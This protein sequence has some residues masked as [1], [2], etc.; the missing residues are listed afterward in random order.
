MGSL[1]CR[2]VLG[3]TLALGAWGSSAAAGGEPVPIA[4]DLAGPTAIVAQQTG[5]GGMD[6]YV[7]EGAAGRVTRIADGGKGSRTVVAEGL[8]QGGLALALVGDKTLVVGEYG[9]G[10]LLGLRLDQRAP[11]APL[12]EFDRRGGPAPTGQLS[13]AVTDRYLFVLRGD[14]L[15]RA[16]RTGDELT[17]L[18]P[19]P[20]RFACDAI[21]T[22]ST[23]YVLAIQSRQGRATLAFRDPHAADSREAS[24]P[25]SGIDG[26]VALAEGPTPRPAERLLYALVR[27]DS[28]AR[29]GVVRLDAAAGEAVGANLVMPIAAPRALAFAHD[30]AMLVA[31]GDAES[32]EVVR[33]DGAW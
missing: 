33:I 12:R 22:S 31:R 24:M 9:T 1:A 4:R 11:P 7:A 5:A 21:A 8:D 32:G 13:I 15:V 3:A 14:E 23:G 10:R 28:P 27:S 29:S 6:L 16:R 25:I 26:V 18:R 19:F 17:T 2:A 20:P 30:G